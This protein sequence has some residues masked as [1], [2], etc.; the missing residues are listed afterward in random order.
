MDYYI[1]L[2]RLCYDLLRPFSACIHITPDI[3]VFHCCFRPHRISH[4]NTFM[5]VYYLVTINNEITNYDYTF[6]PSGSTLLLHTN[7]DRYTYHD[8]TIPSRSYARLIHPSNVF[9]CVLASLVFFRF[10]LGEPKG[11]H[12]QPR[13]FLLTC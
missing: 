12:D 11:N 1:A 4:D 9:F 7:S 13:S 2:L 6:R 5:Y 3:I 10:L 8:F